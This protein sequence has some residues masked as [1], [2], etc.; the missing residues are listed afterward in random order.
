VKPPAA[1]W[2]TIRQHFA[3]NATVFVAAE[4]EIALENDSIVA[5][6]RG[7]NG[8]G[9]GLRKAVVRRHGVLLPVGGTSGVA[10]R[11][12]ICQPAVAA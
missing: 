11:L 6:K 5:L 7:Y 9:K 2:T 4:G 1:D 12:V 10:E 8:I 3:R